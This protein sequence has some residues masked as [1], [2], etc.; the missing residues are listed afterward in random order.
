MNHKSVNSDFKSLFPKIKKTQL[1]SI[2]IHSIVFANPADKALHDRMVKLVETML[3]LHKQLAAARTPQE[4]I[5]LE[6]QI[7][8][9]D[10][11]IDRLVYDLYGLTADEIKIVEGKAD[12]VPVTEEDTK[13]KHGKMAK[14]FYSQKS[15]PL[16]ANESPPGAEAATAAFYNIVGKEEG[17]PY[18]TEGEQP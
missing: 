13:S 11:Q 1:E 6:R 4:K 8:A 2:P 10:T 3:E 17:P 5:A 16:P 9:T 14:G 7:A 18:K 15:P 12:A